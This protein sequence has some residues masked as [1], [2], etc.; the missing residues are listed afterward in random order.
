ME[1]AFDSQGLR[2]ICENEAR[3][4]DELGLAAAGALKNRLAD[5]RAATTIYDLVAG[6][7][8]FLETDNQRLIVDLSNG[9]RIVLEANHTV[10]PTTESGRLDWA[11]ISRIKLLRI[12]S[13]YD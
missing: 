6:R 4:N 2:T 12:E 5:L 7:P 3:A 10:N 9:R 13:D 8:R 1:L 11:R